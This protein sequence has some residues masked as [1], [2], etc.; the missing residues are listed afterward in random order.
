M[1]VSGEPSV[2]FDL[3]QLTKGSQVGMDRAVNTTQSPPTPNTDE[4]QTVLPSAGAIRLVQ[5][6]FYGFGDKD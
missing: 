6:T 3:R 1:N 5:G 4:V 2:C